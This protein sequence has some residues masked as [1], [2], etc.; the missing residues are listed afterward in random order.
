MYC[1]RKVLLSDIVE[2]VFSSPESYSHWF[3]YYN[4]S[5]LDSSNT[6]LLAHRSS[7]DGRPVVSDDFVEIGWISLS[8]GSWSSLGVSRAINWQQGSMLQWLGDKRSGDVVFNDTL[9]DHFIARIVN[10]DGKKDVK[11]SWPIYAI[12]PDGRTSISLQFERSYWCRAYHYESVRN[13]KWN[14]Q[15]SEEDGIFNIDLESN[16]IQRI[17]ALQDVIRLDYDPIFESSKHWLEHVMINPHGNR[18]AFYHRFDDGKGFRTRILT[19][20]LDG[21]DVFM[22]PGWREND[23]SHFGWKNQNDFIVFGANR[24]IVGKIYTSL[25]TNY[26]TLGITLRSAYRNLVSPFIHQRTHHNIA[27]NR[28]YQL[29]RDKQGMIGYY[30]KGMLINDGHPSFTSDGRFML[31]DTY[32]DCDS[33]RHLLLYDT[34]S[35]IVF[36]LGKFYSPFNNCCYRADLHPRFSP[37][38]KFIVIDSAHTGKH[39][40]VVLKID[41][42]KML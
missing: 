27:E 8:D 2:I 33:Y 19:A 4:I 12:T 21:S 9:D 29:Y 25:T 42:S 28:K 3:G 31:T 18:F 22:V 30:S 7:F 35:K 16:S 13:P 32:Q 6:K 38:Q 10:V 40:I 24:L 26:G 20:N 11:I 34:E 15:A 41:W 36:H 5:P 1:D 14:C 37:D 23:W 39:Q 17:I